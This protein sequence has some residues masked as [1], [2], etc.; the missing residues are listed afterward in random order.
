M[1]STIVRYLILAVLLAFLVYPIAYVIPNAALERT[2]PY[3][4]TLVD[5]GTRRD[6]VRQMIQQRTGRDLIASDTDETKM[7]PVEI[8][9]TEGLPEAIEWNQA[10]REL[11]GSARIEGTLR[12][13]T[14]YI[15]QIVTNPFLWECFA[16]SLIVSIGATLLTS[17]VTMPLAIWITRFRFAGRAILSALLLVP[18][19]LPPFVGAIG[20]KQMFS[21]F[22][23]LNLWLMQWGV[24]DGPIDWLGSS[25][26]VGLVVMEALHLY[27][28]MYLN[29]SA[30]LANV[31][32]TLEEAARNL[33]SSEWTLFR[34]VTFPL[35]LPGY[36]AGAAIVFVWAF[37][38]LGT[39]IVLG[40]RRVVPYQIFE[41]LSEAETNPLGYGLVVV[42]LILTALMYYLAR[43]VAGRRGVAMVAKGGIGSAGRK[44]GP[45]R[46][47]AILVYGGVLT[48]F[49]VL[50][51]I[52][53]VLTAF[54]SKWTFTP[55][56]TEYTTDYFV[57]AVT[58]KLAGLSIRNSIVYSLA[59]TF[60]DI[61]LGVSIAYL[62]ARR[63]NWLSSVLDGLS[64]LPLALPGL[65][66]A[67]G[68]LTCFQK[69]ADW[70]HEMGLE[71]LATNLQPQKSPLL[72]LVIAYAMR[73]LPY[74]TRAALA[75]LEQ[76]APAFE[77]AAENLGA[78]RWRVIRQILL[79]LIAANI[80]A[81]S[82]LTF[83]FAVLEVSDSIMLAQR[84]NYFP[85]TKAI[86]MLL[87]R[88][89]DGP[90]IA[91]AMGVLGMLLLAAALITAS[92]LL[93]KRM[94]ELFRA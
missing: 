93:G 57:L 14:F 74:M 13:T 41:R 24:I 29:M 49:A 83:S 79:P 18:L 2:A 82:I 80:V 81:G 23:S 68:Y 59:S 1:P 16:S 11:G 89:D 91:S 28:I 39:P 76:T 25:G 48:L 8:A 88:P 92:A 10:I 43:W 27:P 75:G 37:T 19:I 62:V 87:A 40:Y 65:V 56:P 58:H 42:T 4:V 77:E 31:D 36:F 73:R 12:P 94:G 6:D 3:H 22:G 17:V 72:L 84:E 51:H 44:A 70:S 7:L 21:R 5:P 90:Y 35:V 15:T 64:M 30:A 34:R 38:D 63:P 53:V 46:T 61:V 54:A 66:L 50:P 69:P 60:L 45:V 55:L 32:P 85:I 71:W 47:T 86:Y 78:T 20:F 67:F 26:L 9:K 52:A 33:G